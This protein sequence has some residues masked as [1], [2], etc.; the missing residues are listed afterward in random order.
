MCRAMRRGNVF[1][2]CS[3]SH[4]SNGACMVPVDL[5]TRSKRSCRSL[6][7][8]ISAPPIVALCP[9]I[10]LVVE[11]SE[12]SAPR[13]RGFCSTGVNNVL[14]TTSKAPASRARS[15]ASFISVSLNVGL[16]GVSTN[17]SEAGRDRAS[18][19]TTSFDVSIKSASTPNAENIC[20]SKRTVPP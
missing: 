10:N 15:D 9:S 20:C 2:P 14:S 6:F 18:R 16:A 3:V 1:A 8:V 5:L 4:A 19:K 12:M 13:S 17:T 11:C 7:L